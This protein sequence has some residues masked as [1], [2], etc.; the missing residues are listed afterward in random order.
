MSLGQ[1]RGMGQWPLPDVRGEAE[2]YSA[3]PVASTG[4]LDVTMLVWPHC[5]RDIFVCPFDRLENHPLKTTFI[6]IVCVFFL[7]TKEYVLIEKNSN[8]T[9][10]YNAEANILCN[11]T[12]PRDDSAVGGALDFPVYESVFR[13]EEGHTIVCNYF[14]T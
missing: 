11:P 1:V 14:V 3:P 2:C 12:T 9:K 8:L 4:L 6:F 7:M 5:V 10:I 13:H